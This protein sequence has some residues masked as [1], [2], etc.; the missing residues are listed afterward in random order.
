MNFEKK[1]L[2]KLFFNDKQKDPGSKI[3]FWGPVD[4]IDQFS[5]IAKKKK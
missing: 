2:K 3:S 1:N 5:A 4:K